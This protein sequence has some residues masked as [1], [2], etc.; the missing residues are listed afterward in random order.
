MPRHSNEQVTWHDVDRVRRAHPEWGYSRIALELET[1]A[2]YVRATFQRKHWPKR[3]SNSGPR[4]DG[5]RG[6]VGD[7]GQTNEV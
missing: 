5:S 1:T 2:P 3:S 6:H 4:D 7:E